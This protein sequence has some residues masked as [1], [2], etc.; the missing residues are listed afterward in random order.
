MKQ[1]VREIERRTEADVAEAEREPLGA[2][3]ALR[4]NPHDKPVRSRKDP[5]PWIHAATRDARLALRETCKQLFTAYRRASERL[6]SPYGLRERF[7]LFPVRSFA[8]PGPDLSA[9]QASFTVGVRF[10]EEENNVAA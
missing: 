10:C 4:Q 6:R 1:L 5:A 9:V 8:L 3:R 7:D 2:E